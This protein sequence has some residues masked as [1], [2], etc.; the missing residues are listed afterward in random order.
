ML[1]AI[2]AA[3]DGGQGDLSVT[4]YNNNLALVHDVRNVTLPQGRSRQEFPDVSAQIRPETVT[5]SGEGFGI[6][7]QNYE[8]DLLSPSALMQKAVGQ[9]VTL[10]RTNPATGAETRERALVLAA[11][12]GVVVKIGD[13]IEVLRDDGLPVRVIFDSIPPNLR[14][15]PTLSVTLDASRGGSREL[16]LSYLT[17][18]LGWKADYVTL[19]DEAAGKIDMQGWVTLTN[20]TGTTFSNAKMLLV[21]GAVGQVQQNYGGYR[22]RPVSP[23]GNRPGTESSG[24][25][26]GDFHVYPIEGRTTVANAQTKQVSFL[27]AE[28]VPAK[29]GYEYR[30]GWLGAQSEAQSAASVLKFSS[31][32]SGGV[33]A[34]LPEGTVRVYMRDSQ[35]QAQFIGES[36]IPHTPGGSSLAIRTGDAFDVKVQPVVEKREVVTLDEWVKY[37]RWKVTYPDGKVTEGYAEAPKTYYRTQM[38]YIV[39]NARS[40]PVTVDVVQGGLNQWWWWRDLRVPEESIKGEQDNA[41]QRHW[42]VPVPAN[43]KTE[44]TVTFL[45]PW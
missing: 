1:C 7:E 41:D 8:Y 22:G 4:I 45:T 27:N 30:N 23:R 5:L 11:N 17:P 36:N 14:A 6:V 43:G 12:G 42:E 39:T 33:G 25:Q 2:P 38:R 28:G 20:S 13:R 40:V 9:T 37:A 32:R 19:F 29:K 16:G 31:S 15:R 3:A 24:E 34:A 21:A 10:L 18:G 35:G 44:L 26:L